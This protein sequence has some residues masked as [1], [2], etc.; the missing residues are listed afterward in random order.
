M[1]RP[2]RALLAVFV[3]MYA[4]DA[5]AQ[6]T[7]QISMAPVNDSSDAILYPVSR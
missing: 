6:A 1:N 5:R 3:V 7:A 2:L 4:A